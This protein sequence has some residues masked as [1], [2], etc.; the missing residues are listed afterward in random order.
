MIEESGAM[1]ITK[2][3]FSSVSLVR[4]PVKVGHGRI[5]KDDKIYN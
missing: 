4:R 2:T 1:G 3:D 5:A